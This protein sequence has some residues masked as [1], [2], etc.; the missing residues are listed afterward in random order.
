MLLH[1]L[2][3]CSQAPCQTPPPSQHTQTQSAKALRFQQESTSG[4]LLARVQPLEETAAAAAAQLVAQGEALSVHE[5]A[6]QDA[7]MR[8]GFRCWFRGLAW[9]EG[10]R[11]FLGKLM[12][13]E[14]CREKVQT[15]QHQQSRFY[16]LQLKRIQVQAL[17]QATGTAQQQMVALGEAG[18]A[19]EVRAAALEAAAAE[20]SGCLATH[21]VRRGGDD[22]PFELETGVGFQQS[23]Q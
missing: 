4:Q 11:F 13:L 16:N 20:A 17:E 12:S 21:Q 9:F 7:Q 10:F 15:L 8:V 6:L 1:L 22:L 18:A 19:L 5:G 2:A 3:T 14:P 23:V